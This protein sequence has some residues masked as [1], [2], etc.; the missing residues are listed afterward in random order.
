MAPEVLEG[1]GY[2]F[3]VDLWSFGVI[4][5]EFVCS[6]LPYGEELDD[7]YEIYQVVKN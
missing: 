3:E 6:M 5:Y 1:K 7:P 4:I 2:S